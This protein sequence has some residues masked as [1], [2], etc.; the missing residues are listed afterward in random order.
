M[1]W[2]GAD[3]SGIEWSGAERRIHAFPISYTSHLLD[4]VVDMRIEMM[5][6]LP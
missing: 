4:D 2:T 6:W 5:M 1:D 3:W